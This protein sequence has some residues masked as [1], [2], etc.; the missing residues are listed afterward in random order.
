LK[1][2]S[3][4]VAIA[5]GLASLAAARAD[6]PSG[7]IAIGDITFNY[8]PASWR[9][10]PEG[11][12]LVAT[13]L[14]QDCR[15]AVVDISRRQ[16]EAGCTPEA[17]LVEVERLFPAPG[18]AYANILRT[19]RFALVLAERH[20]GPDLSSP[21][22]A[23]GCLAWEGS[24][25]RFAMRPET[26]GTQ[27]WIGSA[28]HYLVSLA[29]AP[30][31]GEVEVRIGDISLQV[32]TETWTIANGAPEE[33]LWLNCRM[34]TCREPGRIAA[35]SVRLP[36]QPCPPE[37]LDAFGGETMT[38]TLISEAP[39]GLDFTIASTDLGCRNSVPPHI[40][41]CSVH[42]GRSYHLRVLGDEP[43]CRSSGWSIPESAFIDLLKSARMAN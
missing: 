3:L 13:C 21:A 30:A 39:D 9:I 27:A 24:E 22:F 41:A 15:G 38:I 37:H 11:D 7:K 20:T 42:H 29:T 8:K 14:Q 10:V 25:Y 26:V 43:G 35:L 34:P 36:A 2:L 1:R 40:E 23:Y 18:S 33:T 28:L 31:T 6:P 32:S 4:L 5:M 12:R 19:D 16:G 17:M